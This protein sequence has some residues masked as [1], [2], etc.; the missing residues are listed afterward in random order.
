[1][2]SKYY[3]YLKKWN[4]K[5]S[6]ALNYLNYVM[7]SH[8]STSSVIVLVGVGGGMHSFPTKIK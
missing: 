5:N 3:L 8:N 6:D 1:M 7:H 4:Q 2:L